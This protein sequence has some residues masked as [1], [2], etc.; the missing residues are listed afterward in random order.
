ML[1]GAVARFE[2]LDLVLLVDCL[3]NSSISNVHQNVKRKCEHTLANMKEEESEMSW[4]KK[5]I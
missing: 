3:T 4:Y 2:P 1:L 5:S